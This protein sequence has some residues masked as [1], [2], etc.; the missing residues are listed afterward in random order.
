[1][2]VC[3]FQCV[4]QH[5]ISHFGTC[6]SYAKSRKNKNC[7]H[8]YFSWFMC[9]LKSVLIY[10]YSDAIMGVVASQMTASR[11]FTQPF[12]QAQIKENIKAPR[13]WPLW[14][15]FTGDREFHTQRAS[16][17]ENVSIWWRRHV[18]VGSF[19][20][21]GWQCCKACQVYADFTWSEVDV[22]WATFAFF[23]IQK[24]NRSIAQNMSHWGHIRVEMETTS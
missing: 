5:L 14:G 7:K 16:N 17:A 13:H 6:E 18:I 21:D 1:M 8:G 15:E 3:G 20:W 12:I 9:L 4:D 19:H 22:Q 11:L 10:H 2:W 23:I 24:A